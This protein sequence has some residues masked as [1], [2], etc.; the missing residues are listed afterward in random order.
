MPRRVYSEINFHL[1]WHTKNN[2]P[3]ITAKVETRLFHFLTHKILE[4]P[5]V[6]L[7]A[8]GGI[9]DHVHV[10]LSQPPTIKPSE[11]IGKLK[12]GSSHYINQE[13]GYQALEWQSGYGIVSFGSRDL[14]WIIEYVNNQKEH[15]QKGKV[16]DRLERI[17]DY[18]DDGPFG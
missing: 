1:T 11:W 8:I 16:H 12:G 3:L 2:S 14:P 6:L 15:H 10:A 18:D 7:H 13:F 4:T 5:G 9:E 17:S